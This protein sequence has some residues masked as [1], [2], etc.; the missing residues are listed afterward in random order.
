MSNL[1]IISREKCVELNSSF[2]E[3]GVIG[4]CGTTDPQTRTS[5]VWTF[6]IHSRI[7]ARSYVNGGLNIMGNYSTLPI[8]MYAI[9]E[10][11]H[12]LNKLV[13]ALRFSI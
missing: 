2:S 5:Y 1:N 7:I 8:G 11:P 9:R 10:C 4:L 12:D 6:S 3:R 13:A